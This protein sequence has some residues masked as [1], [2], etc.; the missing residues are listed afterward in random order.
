MLKPGYNYIFQAYSD[1]NRV[2]YL[3]VS[4][5]VTPPAPSPQVDPP[6]L[7]GTVNLKLVWCLPNVIFHPLN[8][9]NIIRFFSSPNTNTNIF[10]LK[11]G[12]EYEYEYIRV[13]NFNR[14]RIRI[15]FGFW[16]APNNS[17][18]EYIR[19]KLFEYIRI[20][21]YSLTSG[22]GFVLERE[23]HFHCT[24]KICQFF[25]SDKSVLS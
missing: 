22:R 20:P 15:I 9:S 14:I 21:N 8:Y 23:T 12:T 16:K 24:W 7:I 4:T 17:V 10:G 18:F 3:F 6:T 13:E 11:F 25:F 19:S 5:T 1:W 2:P